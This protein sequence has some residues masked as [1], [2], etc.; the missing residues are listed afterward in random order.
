MSADLGG[1]SGSYLKTTSI[2]T[3]NTV[4]LCAHEDSDDDHDH[5]T[6]VVCEDQSGDDPDTLGEVD[7]VDPHG[8]K[9]LS[10]ATGGF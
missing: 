3:G 1:F 4:F 7:T 10:Y 5:D 6:P 8:L 2:R 9:S